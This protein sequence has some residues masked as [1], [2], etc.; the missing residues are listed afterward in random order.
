MS[1]ASRV[2]RVAVVFSLALMIVGALSVLFFSAGGTRSDEKKSSD[3]WSNSETLPPAD[4]AGKL[5]EK[6]GTP[7]TIF[8][9]ASARFSQGDIFLALHSTGQ[10]PRNK[11]SVR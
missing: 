10:P 7:P 5:A 8:T 4:L 1:A 6:N 11:D 2:R 9:W 3:P